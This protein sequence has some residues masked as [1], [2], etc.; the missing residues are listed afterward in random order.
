MSLP[1]FFCRAS[2]LLPIRSHLPPPPAH[3]ILRRYVDAQLLQRSR[4]QVTI[5]RSLHAGVG[6]VALGIRLH[7]FERQAHDLREQ[8]AD[9]VLG[10][11]VLGR[12]L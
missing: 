10:E 2:F 12:E 6:I 8:L 4:R 11:P 3:E 5:V 9:L 1:T 7:T